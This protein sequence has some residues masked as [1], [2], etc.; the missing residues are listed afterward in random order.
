MKIQDGQ[1]SGVL[2]AVDLEGRIRTNAVTQPF[3]FHI[4]EESGKVWSLPFENINPT[5]ADDYI[6]YI[7][8]TGD[9]DIKIADVRVMADTAATQLELQWV[10]GTVSGG[11]AITA[12]SRN[13]GSA[14]T[15]SATIESGSDLT[16]LTSGGTIFFIQC[17]TVNKEEH[18]STSSNII[19]PKGKAIALQVE[20]ATANI[21]GV[22]S[23]V[24]SE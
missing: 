1:G 8:N 5:G 19:I 7:K 3:D 17:P 18:L 14:A 24:E 2:A 9:K 16:G 11:A 21:T 6:F 10:S 15:P 23:I 4:N 12:V 22:I 13:G 20:T